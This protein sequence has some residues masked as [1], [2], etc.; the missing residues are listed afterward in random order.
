MCVQQPQEHYHQKKTNLTQLMTGTRTAVHTAQLEAH[1]GMA[2]I[3]TL[4]EKLTPEPCRHQVPNKLVI[5]KAARETSMYATTQCYPPALPT[6][7][8]QKAP[9]Y[10][11]LQHCRPLQLG[12]STY[13]MTPQP[14]VQRL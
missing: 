8:L 13:I 9:C 3:E 6:A 5:N 14:P 7:S 1:T 11:Y 2:K 10:D 12:T 4:T